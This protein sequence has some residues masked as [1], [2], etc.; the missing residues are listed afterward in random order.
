MNEQTL[1]IYRGVGDTVTVW[2]IWEHSCNDNPSVGHQV[3]LMVR[4]LYWALLW[5]S[6]ELMYDSQIRTGLIVVTYQKKSR[7]V[8]ITFTIVTTKMSVQSCIQI[9]AFI[10][11]VAKVTCFRSYISSV[12]NVVCHCVSLNWVSS[13]YSR[14][15]IIDTP[16][17]QRS[18]SKSINYR[19]I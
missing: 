9:S 6:C 18:A 17:V 14:N 12:W 19:E 1:W 16:F 11:T 13:T 10:F 5:F 7:K 2:E 3:Y 8:V 4:F 15:P